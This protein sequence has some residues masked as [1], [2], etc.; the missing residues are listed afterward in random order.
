[1]DSSSGFLKHDFFL[2]RLDLRSY[3][4]NN[5]NFKCSIDGKTAHCVVC[6]A[7]SL[8]RVAQLSVL[9]ESETCTIEPRLPGLNGISDQ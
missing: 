1:M 5:E 7:H 3:L 9:V 4:K 8:L 2:V 6:F